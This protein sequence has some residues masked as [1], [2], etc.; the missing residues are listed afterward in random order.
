MGGLDESAVRYLSLVTQ[1]TKHIRGRA[2]KERTS[3]S[4]M[5]QFSPIF[6][7]LLKDFY[8][9][10]V[11]EDRRITPR[12]YMELFLRPVQGNGEKIAAKNEICD[13]IRALFPDRECYRLVRPS[14]NEDDLLRLDQILLDKLQ[15]EFRSGPDAFTK[16]VF[17]RPRPKQVGATVMTVPTIPS[18]WRGVEE[19]ECQKAYNSATDTYMSNFDRPKLPEEVALSEAHEEAVQK[20]LA[21]YNAGAVGVGAARKKYEGLLMKFF[22]K[23]FEDYKRNIFMEAE[24]QCSKAIQSMEKRL[25]AA[26]H[27]SDA[28]IDNVVKKD[29]SGHDVIKRTGFKTCYCN[30]NSGPIGKLTHE[31]SPSRS[32]DVSLVGPEFGHVQL[33]AKERPTSSKPDS[34]VRNNIDSESH[35]NSNVPESDASVEDLVSIGD[36]SGEWEVGIGRS[37]EKIIV[38]R[39]EAS[40]ILSQS[41]K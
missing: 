28:N 39:M 17:E 25:R 7:F 5:G 27:S 13:S 29:G 33:R 35:S 19:A 32:E 2:S 37:P 1:M 12:D 22:K 18:L 21:V 3:A 16:F 9:E 6:V 26:C 11:E 41:R 14:N 34:D 36:Y 8:L 15:R 40:S 4:E 10:L 31:I 20:S 23:A 38:D 24:I 30:Q